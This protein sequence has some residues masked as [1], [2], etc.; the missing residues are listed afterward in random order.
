MFP[1]ADEG[2]TQFV[3]DPVR[4]RIGGVIHAEQPDMVFWSINI[5]WN[6]PE[7]SEPSLR[8]AR[9]EID[10]LDFGTNDWRCLAGKEAV[11]AYAEDDVHPIM[12]GGPASFY[13]GDH[14]VPNQNHLRL[15]DRR[16]RTFRVEW[17]CS[18]EFAGPPGQLV[19]ISEDI[20]LSHVTVLFPHSRAVN[21]D[22]ARD[23]IGRHLGLSDFVEQVTNDSVRFYFRDDV[24]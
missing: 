10:G 23:I 8:H 5:E 6:N 15:S 19:D 4:S 18:L 7:E 3:V 2:S 14:A 21:P 16:G 12:P 20:V 22:T 11:S 13:Y 24:D 17:R 9:I 1:L